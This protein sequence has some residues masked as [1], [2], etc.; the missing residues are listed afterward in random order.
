MASSAAISLILMGTLAP[1]AE[2]SIV[3]DSALSLGGIELGVPAASVKSVLG[4]PSAE[5]QTDD[6]LPVEMRYAGFTVWLDEAGRV[7]EILSTSPKYCT[8]QGACPG[9]PFSKVQAL[10]GKP[11]VALREDGRYMEYY[12]TS[13]F[14]C[15]LQIAV[16]S[17]T[18]RSIRSECQP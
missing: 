14:P 4:S 15:W 17:G 11:M 2:I 16:E 10:Y 5:R 1:G 9:Q 7:G 8:P 18:V 3:P 13:D 12:P 6:F